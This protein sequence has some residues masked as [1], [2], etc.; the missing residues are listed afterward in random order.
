MSNP[1]KIAYNTAVQLIGKAATAISTAIIIYLLVIPRFSAGDFGIFNTILSYV[2]LFYVFADFGLNAIFVRE[3]GSDQEKQKDYFK[4]LFGLRLVASILVAFV[5]TA[6]LAFAGYPSAAKIGIIIGLGIL[7]T[8]TFAT[9]A[10][11]LFQAKV[12]YDQAVLADIIGAAA[13]LILVFLAT[14]A[15]D[16]IIF[17]IAALVAGGAIR[18]LVGFYI[19]KFQIGDISPS[20]DAEFAR[21]IV[22]AA[23][24]VGLI[25]IFSQFNAQIDKQVVIL[26]NYKP[27]LHLTGVAAAGFYGFA[28]KIF[29]VALVFPTFVM[30]VGYP[31]M[32]QK[33]E[34]GV[35]HLL[36]FSKKLA[37]FLFSL[38]ILGLILGWVIAPFVFDISLFQKFSPSLT[39]LRILLLGFPLF[40][41]TPVSLWL[42][43]TLGKTKEMMF[44]YGFAAAFNL[45]ANL[46]FVPVFGY[47]AAAIVT[48]AS[49]L[50]IL[51]L[52]AGV[53]FITSKAADL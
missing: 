40:F 46:V 5:A 43:V 29:E 32:V 21:K 45:V 37:L 17:V 20:F 16:S 13:N 15:F 33:K 4:K 8:Q 2:A 36:S 41:I 48:I 26:A 53:L 39:A 10:L 30:N 24:P 34:A 47:N 27:A 42:A 51:A 11:A 3:V 35:D 49:E 19:V 22:W 9:T 50:I 23:F 44:V 28:Y 31:L 6:I 52:T 7:I 38:G 25:A 18:V 14:R 1:F 12:R